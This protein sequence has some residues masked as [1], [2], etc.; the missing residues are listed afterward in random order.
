MKLAILSS[1][2]TIILAMLA[3]P[4]PPC[5]CY[6]PTPAPKPPD[7]TLT[8]T[9]LPSVTEDSANLAAHPSVSTVLIGLV[10]E[11]VAEETF[12]LEGGETSVR[13][14]SWRVRVERY[15]VDAQPYREI[16]VRLEEMF[17][18]PDGTLRPTR[19]PVGLKPGDR[20]VFVLVRDAGPNRPPLAEGAFT[21]VTHG[22]GALGRWTVQDGQVNTMLAGQGRREPL[23]E[24]VTRIIGVAEGAGRTTGNM[25]PT[26]I[27]TP[28]PVATKPA[29]ESP[30]PTAHRR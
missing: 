5:R 21:L 26:P 3:A 4:A 24:F 23:E 15:L 28:W 8:T 19:F 22:P 13:F 11:K 1:L 14:G 10:D 27:P 30:T 18:Q 29:E 20:A 2:I 7:E 16:L 6:R 25:T 9:R 12:L 17:V